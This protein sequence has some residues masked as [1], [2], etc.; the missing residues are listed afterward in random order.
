MITLV[1]AQELAAKAHAKAAELGV[2][3]T[4]AVTDA[5]GVVVL[6]ERNEGALVV[7]PTFAKAKAYTAA[8]LCM[9]TS[10]LAGFTGDGKPYAGLRDLSKKFTTI[11]GGLPITEGEQVVGGIGVGGS[12]DPTQDEQC[13]A[14]ALA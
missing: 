3:V 9:P 6:L 4:V 1:K 14:A 10:A 7:S 5:S 11:A 13:A 2:K 8:T 12:Q